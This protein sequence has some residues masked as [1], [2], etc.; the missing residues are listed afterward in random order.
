MTFILFSG[1]ALYATNYVSGLHSFKLVNPPSTRN[2]IGNYAIAGNTV[3]CLTEKTSGYGGTCHGQND[4]QK[5]TS[6]LHVSKYIDIDG[7]NNGNS[8]TWNSSSS[9]IQLPA[10]LNTSEGNP[11]LWAGLFW[12]G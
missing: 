9:Y 2:I 7:N 3:M 1:N 10:N 5:V 8:A 6:N 11:V 12:Q 4:Y